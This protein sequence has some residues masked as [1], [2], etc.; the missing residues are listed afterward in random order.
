MQLGH[1]FQMD[2]TDGNQKTQKECF[3]E[4]LTE[5][6]CLV[7]SWLEAQDYSKS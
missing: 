2:K 4:D 5:Y 6:Q 1:P 7:L 3:L